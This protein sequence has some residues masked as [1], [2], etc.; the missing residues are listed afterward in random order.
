M[1]RA[2]AVALAVMVVALLVFG[3]WPNLVLEAAKDGSH[4]FQPHGLIS[5]GA[6]VTA[7]N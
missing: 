5:V 3:L 1:P 2:A 4:A 7:G 6:P